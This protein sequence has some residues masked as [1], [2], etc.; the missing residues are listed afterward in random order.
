MQHLY[1]HTQH[2]DTDAHTQTHR[3]TYEHTSIMFSGNTLT[4]SVPFRSDRAVDSKPIAF[5]LATSVL[6]PLSLYGAFYQSLIM[7]DA[8]IQVNLNET[9]D[10]LKLFQ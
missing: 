2:T 8:C 6:R 4:F 7:I 9:N 10:V 1:I 3:P 5:A